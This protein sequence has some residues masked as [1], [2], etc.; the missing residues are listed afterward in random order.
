MVLSNVDGRCAKGPQNRNNYF[1]KPCAIG[2]STVSNFVDDTR[3]IRLLLISFVLKGKLSAVYL[4]LPLELTWWIL[5]W[6]V[7]IYIQ[8]GVGIPPMIWFTLGGVRDIRGVFQ[9]LSAVDRDEEEVAV[10][11]RHEQGQ[12]QP[13]GHQCA[14]TK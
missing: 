9:R 2:N 4:I 14:G 7:W 11:H 13:K 3:S 1:G 8:I 5:F 10:D 6:K 12:H